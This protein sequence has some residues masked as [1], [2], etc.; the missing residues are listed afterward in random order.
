MATLLD[1]DIPEVQA[2]ADAA[3]DILTRLEAAPF[4]ARLEAVRARASSE[5]PLPVP[6]SSP[7]ATSSPTRG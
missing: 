7:I 5:R 2:A 4:V 3:M 1:P 6:E